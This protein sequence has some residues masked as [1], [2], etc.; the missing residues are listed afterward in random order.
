MKLTT[1][2]ILTSASFTY[3]QYLP[4]IDAFPAMGGSMASPTDYTPTQA[5]KSCF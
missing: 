4:S 3:A 5:T 1:Y 2:V